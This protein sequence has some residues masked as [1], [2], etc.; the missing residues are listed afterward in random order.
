[1]LRGFSF[2]T[3][4][5]RGNATTQPCD[6]GCVPTN[7]FSLHD[8]AKARAQRRDASQQKPT[9]AQVLA[10]RAMLCEEMQPTDTAALAVPLPPKPVSD[11]SRFAK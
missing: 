4:L 2:E 5:G 8:A 6:C 3:L 1:M 7:L 10:Q 9:L 11:Q